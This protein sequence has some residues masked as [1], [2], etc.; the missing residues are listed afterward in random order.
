MKNNL[1]FPLRG[2]IPPLVTPLLDNE[3]LDLDGLERLIEHVISGGVHGVF[4][5]GTTGEFASL[6]HLLKYELIKTT[7]TLVNKRVPV[8]VG[9]SDSAFTE[10]VNLARCAAENGADAVV[11][12]PPYYF[13]S[14]QPELLEYLNR[15]MPQIPLPLFIYN[16]PVHTKVMFAPETVISAAE[17]SGIVGM[18]DSSG[19]LTYFNQIRYLM[20][21]KCPDFTFMIGP[22][23]LLS[24]FV[25]MGGH[26][27]VNGGANLFPGLYVD[28]YKAS[29]AKDFERISKL[30]QKVIQIST[31]LYT[32]GHYGSSYL[33]GLK[34]AL[35]VTGV[36]NDFMAEPFHR[37]KKPERSRV[38]E[39]IA[40]LE[41]D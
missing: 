3:T 22:E 2:I 35:S 31:S 10:S 33:K 41:L 24:E 15:I 6:S 28:L 21:D 20:K 38:K 23:E 36:C 7:C 8:L 30:R 1:N 25:L 40:A 13:A 17:I 32:I 11:L 12:T 9:V 4:I 39:A 18:K 16:M 34:C 26:G 27:G 14:A 37:F 19:N 29:L 5:L